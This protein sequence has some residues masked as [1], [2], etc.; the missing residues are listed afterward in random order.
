M[1]WKHLIEMIGIDV[2]ACFWNPPVHLPSQGALREV[3]KSQQP[4]APEPEAP[5]VP[6]VKTVKANM[7]KTDEVWPWSHLIPFLADDIRARVSGA[8]ARVYGLGV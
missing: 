7:T 6:P 5:G 1:L 8:R 4:P 3:K 2:E